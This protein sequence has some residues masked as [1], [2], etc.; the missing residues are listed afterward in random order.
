MKKA[1][2]KNYS[3]FAERAY[4][5]V[6][7]IQK[8]KTL[9]YAQVARMAGSPRAHRAVGSILSKNWNP[10]IPCHRVVR[11]SG[12]TGGYNRGALRKAARLRSEGAL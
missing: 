1:R 10:K 2:L 5:V 6:A 9:T 7:K 3:K 4:A 8:G 11:L 12:E